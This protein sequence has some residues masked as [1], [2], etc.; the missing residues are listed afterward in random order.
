MSEYKCTQ[1]GVVK[2]KDDFYAEKRNIFKG[3][4]SRCKDCIKANQRERNKTHVYTEA[5]R[6]RTRRWEE[7][8]REKVRLQARVKRA[9]NLESCRASTRKWEAANSAYKAMLKRKVRESTPPWAEKDLMNS[10]Y[11]MSR[12]L[13]LEVD[14]IVPLNH[15]L[16][17]GLHCWHNLQ[18]L[19]RSLNA[20]KGNHW[21]PDMP[22]TALTAAQLQAL[23]NP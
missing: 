15:P 1:C 19:E 8:N 12:I 21:W 23:T 10:V 5:D 17:S 9:R 2:P 16:V 18:L 6:E 22:E 4:G 20:S 14:H 3:C 13:D 11:K 7:N